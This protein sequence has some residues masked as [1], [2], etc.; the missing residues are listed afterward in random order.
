MLS[1]PSFS[2]TNWLYFM[3]TTF[4]PG[5]FTESNVSRP[6]SLKKSPT[7]VAHPPYLPLYIFCPL[8]G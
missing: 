4:E 5:C 6:W 1:T 7:G 3:V 2:L 8:Y